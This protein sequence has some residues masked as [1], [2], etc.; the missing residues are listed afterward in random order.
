MSFQ[1]IQALPCRRSTR[2]VVRVLEVELEA[3]DG[4]VDVVTVGVVVVL[5]PTREWIE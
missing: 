5:S 4:V 3:L 2:N 1:N